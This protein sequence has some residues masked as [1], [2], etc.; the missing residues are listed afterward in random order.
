M[1]HHG[2]RTL[3][4]M[5]NC[6][7][8]IEYVTSDVFVTRRHDITAHSPHYV[9]HCVYRTAQCSPHHGGQDGAVAEG[10]S[11]ARHQEADVEE[12]DVRG[13]AVDRHD[14]AGVQTRLVAEPTC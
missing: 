10:D 5:T 13:A 3:C 9:S 4:D 12:G 1:F 6:G 14:A 11:D 2:P 8:P 7:S